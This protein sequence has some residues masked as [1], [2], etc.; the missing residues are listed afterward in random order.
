MKY[1]SWGDAFICKDENAFICKDEDFTFQGNGSVA[2][3]GSQ[4]LAVHR[5]FKRKT[6]KFVPFLKY[7]EEKNLVFV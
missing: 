1:T 3:A 2:D 5:S 6:T 7:E 4:I